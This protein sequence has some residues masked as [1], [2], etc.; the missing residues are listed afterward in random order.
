M[1][2]GKSLLEPNVQRPIDREVIFIAEVLAAMQSETGKRHLSSI[3]PEA[4]TA[5]TP[6]C[7][8]RAMDKEAVQM[9]AAPIEGTL[10]SSQNLFQNAL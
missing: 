2:K 6:N 7:I 8:G 1:I 3:F 4:D 5:P 10:G 9:F